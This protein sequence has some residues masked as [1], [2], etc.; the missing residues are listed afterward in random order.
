MNT[1]FKK[2]AV[3][4][5]AALAV[6]GAVA[7]T[8]SLSASADPKQYDA[9]VG[10]GSDTTQDVLNALA[11]HA[12]GNN[13]DPVQT[14]SVTGQKQ[15][16]SFNATNPDTGLTDCIVTKIGGPALDRP[17]GSSAGRRALSRAVDGT[18]F[19]TANCGGPVNV[20]G[21]VDFARSSSGPSSGDTGTDLTY[22][23]FG[24]DAVS[25]AYY[26]A[27]GN[28]VDTLT[29]AELTNLFINGPQTIDGVR[30]VP[31]GI[32]DGSGTY[33]FWNRVTTATEAQEDT[34][35]ALCNGLLGRAQEN[36]AVDLKDRGDALAAVAGEADSQVV[37]GFSAG[38]FIAKSNGVADP[39][40]PA[41][42]GIGN[43]DD[44]G[45]G[46]NL[47]SPVTGTAPNLAP[48]SSFYANGTF[49]RQVYNVLPTVVIDSL[50]GNNDLKS[51][52]KDE[53]P[54]PANTATLCSATA[55]VETFGFQVAPNCGDTSLK[56]S[57]RSGQN[58]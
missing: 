46:N 17:N 58:P 1:S 13:F 42:T 20:S 16:I 38:S 6:T 31:C 52:F 51:M 2:V 3:R 53:D 23:P 11:G 44:D 33:G 22:I 8:M 36:D 35:T 49:G 29:R 48:N 39:L 26:R 47:G 41:E 9:F 7:S 25:F 18:G 55:T 45:A 57:F 34:A 50:F 32:Q 19:G 10:L 30:I 37:I 40:P 24:N 43:I 56:G 12:N 21:F 4:T 27:A 15:L 28:P 14:S 5:V 54:G